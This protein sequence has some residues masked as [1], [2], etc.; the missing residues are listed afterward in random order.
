MKGLTHS[1]WAK[2]AAFFLAV[3]IV[4]ALTLYIFAAGFYY[5]GEMTDRFFDSNAFDS[6]VYSALYDVR[7]T[8]VLYADYGYGEGGQEAALDAL[9]DLYPADDQSSNLRFTLSDKASGRV[10]YDNRCAGDPIVEECDVSCGDGLTLQAY[11]AADFPARDQIYWAQ[12]SYAL[13]QRLSGQ[14]LWM[15][16][17]LSAAE[18]F[19]VVWLARAA[20]RRADGSVSPGWQEKLPFDV[21]LAVAATLF[22]CAMAMIGEVTYVRNA[23][24]IP[25]CWSRRRGW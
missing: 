23:G 4:P 13:L 1:F 3:L 17:L 19:L 11:L 9:A 15:I 7:E 25:R 21:Y 16:V 10:L 22:L 5:S 8:Y 14:A 12:Q 6:V 18:V 24:W 2:A 20:G